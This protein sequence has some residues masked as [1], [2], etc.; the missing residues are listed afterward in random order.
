MLHKKNKVCYIIAC[1]DLLKTYII[2]CFGTQNS[3]PEKSFQKI[4]KVKNIK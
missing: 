3:K 2:C 1:S 4:E